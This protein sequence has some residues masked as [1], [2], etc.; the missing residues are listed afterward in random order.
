M[1]TLKDLNDTIR[2][3]YL[4]ERKAI[5]RLALAFKNGNAEKDVSFSAY[6]DLGNFGP[7]NDW[8]GQRSS[9]E[10]I[11]REWENRILN[12]ALALYH[13]LKTN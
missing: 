9:A 10:R 1:Q 12:P 2:F 4:D 6:C 7:K 11:A 8:N 13:N 5:A 3:D